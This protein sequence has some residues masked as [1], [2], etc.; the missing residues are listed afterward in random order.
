MASCEKITSE[1]DRLLFSEVDEDTPE[2]HHVV[3]YFKSKIASLYGDQSKALKKIATHKDRNCELLKSQ[4]EEIGIIV[5]KNALTQ[6]FKPLKYDNVFEIKT[7]VVINPIQNAGKK[8]AMRLIHRISQLAVKKKA[9][10]IFVTVSSAKPESLAFF[11]GRGFHIE[12]VIKDAY[13]KGLDEYYL[14]HPSPE[15]L[16]SSTSLELLTPVT[17]RS[18]IH[19]NQSPTGRFSFNPLEKL[20]LSSYFHGKNTNQ[21]LKDVCEYF[22]V[23]ASAPLL[24][25]AIA[26][27]RQHHL[28]WQPEKLA[29]RYAI[30]FLNP[31]YAD[32]NKQEIIGHLLVGI[33]LRGK[34]HVLGCFPAKPLPQSYWI[35]VFQDLRNACGVK[36]IDLLSTS[37]N[38]DLSTP[39]HRTFPLSRSISS[40]NL[41]AWTTESLLPK[42]SALNLV[43][44]LLS[45]KDIMTYAGEKQQPCVFDLINR[46]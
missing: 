27:L 2:F 38:I 30:V 4:D 5:Y 40:E 20:A 21:V 1:P 44:E 18:R 25:N 15:K 41:K 34:R 8:I 22:G 46:Q 32:R 16:L 12:K 29:H 31:L 6:E 36:D 43:Y 10:S 28:K 11:L 45:I 37:P 9:T 26:Q 33:T 17:S 13:L 42:S 19:L 35:G 14:F 23:K 7:L 3:S 39:L 24:L